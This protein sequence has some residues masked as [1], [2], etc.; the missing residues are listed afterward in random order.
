[1]Q[2]EQDRA[3][4]LIHECSSLRSTAMTIAKYHSPT[5]SRRLIHQEDDRAPV[6][7]EGENAVTVDRDPQRAQ[8]VLV[9]D[10]PANSPDLRAIRGTRLEC[11]GRSVGRAEM[12]ID[13]NATRWGSRAPD[14]T[15][16]ENLLRARCASHGL[17]HAGRPGATREREGQKQV[18]DT[19]SH[20]SK[21]T[22]FSGAGGYPPTRRG[23]PR[24][25]RSLRS[26]GARRKSCG[27]GCARRCA[28]RGCEPARPGPMRIGSKR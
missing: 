12:H 3:P 7:P 8:V 17:R 6:E 15:D 28:R 5:V 11:T 19:P 13:E 10:L 20:P 23:G 24:S 2:V 14:V 16:I 1:M 9:L 27:G 18:Q 21:L 4:E 22:R 26:S 25:A